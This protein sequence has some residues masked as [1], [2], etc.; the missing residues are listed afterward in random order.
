[1]AYFISGRRQA[2]STILGW[3]ASPSLPETRTLFLGATTILLGAL[4]LKTESEVIWQAL[5]EVFNRGYTPIELAH[6]SIEPKKI[7]STSAF[8]DMVV[9]IITR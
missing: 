8:G 2:A 3:P 5:F 1:M 7:L 9:E 4:N 6:S